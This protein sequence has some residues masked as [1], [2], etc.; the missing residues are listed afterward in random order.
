MAGFSNHAGILPVYLMQN[1]V[2]ASKNIRLTTGGSVLCKCIFQQRAEKLSFCYSVVNNEACTLSQSLLQGIQIF[3]NFFPR[4][5]VLPC[6]HFKKGRSFRYTPIKINWYCFAFW[7]RVS[8][9][10][11]K[12]IFG[13]NRNKQKQDL[14]RV[15][16]GFFVKPKTKNFGLFWFVSVFRTYIETTE[17]YRTVS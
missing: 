9:K 10:Q 2:G 8:S 13:S 1:S 17:T 16:F 6:E 15:C 14:F 7:I 12:I 5:E 3:L 11:T 4:L